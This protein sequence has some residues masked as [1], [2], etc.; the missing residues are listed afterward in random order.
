MRRYT[1]LWN[2]I[3]QKSLWFSQ[4]MMVSVDMSK[5]GYIRLIFVDPE[6]KVNGVYYRDVLLS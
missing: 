6:V 4:S 1:T 3:I 2:I 5:L